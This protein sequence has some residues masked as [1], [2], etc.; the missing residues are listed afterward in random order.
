MTVPASVSLF[1]GHTRLLQPATRWLVCGPRQLQSAVPEQAANRLPMV[2][3]WLLFLA[4]SEQ[5][6]LCVCCSNKPVPDWSRADAAGTPHANEQQIKD[7]P[8]D[9]M[10]ATC[11]ASAVKPEEVCPRCAADFATAVQAMAAH[12]MCNRTFR[13]TEQRS[14]LL[15]WKDGSDTR[16]NISKGGLPIDLVQPFPMPGAPHI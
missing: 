10:D 6:T 13:R 12:G 5:A 8:A 14:C 11:H 4:L 15:D 1:A 2:K 3:C 7:E 16:L 9:D